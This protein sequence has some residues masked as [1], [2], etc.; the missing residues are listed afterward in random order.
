VRFQLD[1]ALPG[2]VQEVLAAFTDPQFLTSA[3]NLGKVGAPEVL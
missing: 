2:S 3:G 1:Q